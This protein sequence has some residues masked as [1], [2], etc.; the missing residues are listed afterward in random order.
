MTTT[1]SE[2]DGVL[3][4]INIFTVEPEQQKQLVQHL[5]SNLE[6]A[7]KQPGFISANIHQSLDGTRVVNYAQ[8]TSQESLEL[9]LQNQEFMSPVKKAVEYPHEFHRYEVV[10][11]IQAEKVTPV[12]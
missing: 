5:V 10:S 11:T 9:A 3:T 2:K 4:V 8:W 12:H 7:K 6:T 1:I